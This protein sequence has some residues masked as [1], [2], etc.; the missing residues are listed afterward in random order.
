[1]V[2][3]LTAATQYYDVLCILCN[4]INPALQPNSRVPWPE[5]QLRSGFWV[6]ESNARIPGP[7]IETRQILLEL[8]ARLTASRDRF[9]AFPNASSQGQ[10]QIYNGFNVFVFVLTVKKLFS[11]VSKKL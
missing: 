2:D 5:F 6:Q 11:G 9:G 1:M 3:E 10:H 4:H 7:K 8:G